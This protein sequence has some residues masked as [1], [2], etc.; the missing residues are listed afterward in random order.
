M[1]QSNENDTPHNDD[2]SVSLSEVIALSNK[3]AS[4]V[5]TSLDIAKEQQIINKRDIFFR[6]MRFGVILICAA[7]YVLAVFN[8]INP[9]SNMTI[10][11]KYVAKVRVDGEIA[12]NRAASA[13]NIIPALEEAFEDE[14]AIGVIIQINSPGGSPVQA[15]SIYERIREL[16]RE[17]PD[18]KVIAIG[19]DMLTSGAYMIAVG[20]DK[21][22]INRSTIAGSIGVRT[23][24][25]GFYELISNI[26][27]ERRLFTAG[28]HKAQLDAFMPAK[29]SDVDRIRSMLSEVHMHFID[30]VK[31]SRG[32]LLVGSNED[33]FS[34]DVWVGNRAID[35][36]IAD[37]IGS[38]H[39]VLESE[40]DVEQVKDFT[41]RTSVFGR[42]G[43]SFGA[44]VAAMLTDS[45]PVYVKY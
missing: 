24:G 20:A 17:H 8:F 3:Y 12:S 44:S 14:E 11:G 43:K 31:E 38:M 36:G 18:K 7:V 34:G 19:E 5:E 39:S 45:L 32:G 9:P 23:D 28:E 2:K 35:V 25:F 15:S 27:I 16:R 26:G 1:P 21:I 13:D 42:L 6:N 30:T 22:Y 37:A 33:L 40:Y 29:E 41:K 4:A 10:D